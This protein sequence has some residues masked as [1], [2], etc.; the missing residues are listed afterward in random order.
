MR[1][2]CVSTG[3]TDHPFPTLLGKGSSR[4]ASCAGGAAAGGEREGLNLVRKRVSW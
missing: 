3:L 2:L 1:V 4:L